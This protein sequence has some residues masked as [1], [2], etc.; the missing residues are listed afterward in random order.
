[1]NNLEIG[2]ILR[3]LTRNKVGAILIAIQIAF[4]MTIVV[5][6]IS[7]IQERERLM[8]RESG[9]D[10]ANTFFIDSSGFTD[11]FNEKVTIQEDLANI[12]ALPDVIS[13][14]QINAVPISG[15][16]WSMTLQ[17]TENAEG[18][19][20]GVAVYMTDENGLET[21]DLE[22]IAG[23]NFSSTDV[24]W[25]ER[26]QTDWPDKII[27]TKVMADDL[28]PEEDWQHALGKTVFIQD[29]EPLLIIGIVDKLQAPWVGWGS[30]ER[31]MISPEYQLF[32][33]ARYLIRAEP[34]FRDELMPQVEE[35][36]AQSNDGRIIRNLRSIEDQRERSYQSHS[37]MVKM[38]SLIMA[39]LILV[40]GL[41]IVG[42]ASFN[43]N[44]RKKQIGVRRALGATQGAIL[45]YFMVEN[46]LISSI[47]VLL[48]AT[49]S[50]GLNIILVDQ[51]SLTPIDWYLIPTGM[52]ALWMVGQIAVFGPAQ[53]AAGI[54]PAS[55]TR[56]V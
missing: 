43:V 35:L 54:S 10:D 37:A 18:D 53:R 2:P 55:A 13:A 50:V 45:R 34:G 9:L 38:L 24:R 49:L 41:G 12:R 33:S 6:A 14:V 1:M 40:T 51:F 17:T 21:L 52:I 16:G 26:V 31:S 3:A 27:I 8:A 19:G 46:F 20:T 32:G 25:R 5:N 48:G 39:V 4:T 23:E 15:S 7:I 29:D 47:G 11:D 22:L 30:V 28:Y 56:T 44:R 36:L 42:L